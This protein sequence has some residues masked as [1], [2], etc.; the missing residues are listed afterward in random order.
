MTTIIMPVSRDTFLQQ[1]FARLEYLECDPAQVSLLTYVDG[2]QPLFEKARNYT[3]QSKFAQRLCVY[4]HKGIANVG[5]VKA[6]RKRIADIH[7]EIKALIQPSQFILSIEDDTL[8]PV[9][10]L[11]VLE[12][13]FSEYPHAGFISAVEL[14]RWGYSHVGG[15]RLDDIYEP[16]TITSVPVESGVVP[17]D[18]AGL[19]CC[20]M[21]FDT[22]FKHNFEAYGEILGPDVHFGIKLRQMGVMN[23]M[24]HRLQCVHLTKRGAI[25]IPGTNIVQVRFSKSEH[26]PTGW[27]LSEL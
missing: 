7:N 4:R 16:T 15:W 21:R 11:R 26:S 2:P 20:L 8:I 14:G 19:Y 25:N 13:G 22:Y 3:I 5:S 27:Q 17:V 18:A 24:D 9:D 12:R 1:I 23:Y 10:T 6:R